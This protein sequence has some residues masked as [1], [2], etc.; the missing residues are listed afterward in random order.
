MDGVPAVGSGSALFQ[1]QVQVAAIKKQIDATREIGEMALKLIQSAS[2]DPATG[3]R[4]DVL[5]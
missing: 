5:A 3:N 1:A 2:I 4:I